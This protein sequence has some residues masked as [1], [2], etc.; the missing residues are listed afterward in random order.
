MNSFS[1]FIRLLDSCTVMFQGVRRIFDSMPEICIDVPTAYTL[2]DS[3]GE[4]MDKHNLLSVE[5]LK[6]LPSRFV[7]RNMYQ[8]GF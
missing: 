7:N 6:D 4:K 8:G 5:L 1:D 2:L 3:L